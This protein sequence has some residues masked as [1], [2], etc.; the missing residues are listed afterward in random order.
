M[1]TVDRYVYPAVFTYEDDGEIS[2]TFPDFP[3]CV[4][5]ATGDAQAIR[6][7]REALG[8]HIWCMEVDGDAM[9]EPT[10][11]IRVALEENE[12]AVPV[13]VYM[14][15]IRMAKET[16]SVTRTITIPAWLNAAAQERGENFSQ[17]LQEALMARMG[18]RPRG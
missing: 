13:D 10:R 12:R 16:R 6:S 15:A 8:G 7:A 3:G 4:S 2:I 18:M 9:P 5:V 11:L 17:V 14:P 1:K